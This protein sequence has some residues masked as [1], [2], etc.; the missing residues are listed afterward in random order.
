MSDPKP[1][2]PSLGRLIPLVLASLFAAGLLLAYAVN[3]PAPA[4][5]AMRTPAQTES[6][7]ADDHSSAPASGA[8]AKE[9]LAQPDALL[10]RISDLERALDDLTASTEA[11]RRQAD[12][13]LAEA[14]ERAGLCR[15]ALDQ[16]KQS[17]RQS[18]ETISRLHRG[19]ADLGARFT[20][21]GLLIALGEADLQFQPGQGNLASQ[22]SDSL[23]KLAGIL[24]QNPRIMVRVE[25]HTDG[26][27]QAAANLALSARRA[28]AVK[29][30]LT[31]LGVDPGRIQTEG[32][33]EA[34]PITKDQTAEGRSRNRRV[35][36]YVIEP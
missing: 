26:Q 17:V 14:T 12:A 27:G 23:V 36:I 8:P 33:G 11:A 15:Q 16:A 30:M 20:E 6:G 34:R 28:E 2:D 25:G 29:G 5:P 35:E 3:P 18:E 24:E 4:Q 19:Y 22:R 31:S 9:P 32:I 1:A 21:R 7:P 10:Q 13:Q